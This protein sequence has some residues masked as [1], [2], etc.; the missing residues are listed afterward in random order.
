MENPGIRPDAEKR[1]SWRLARRRLS[2]MVSRVDLYP[3]VEIATA[4]VAVVIG[5][6]SYALVSGVRTPGAGLSPAAANVLPGAQ[7]P[8]PIVPH[9]LI[10]RRPAR[11]GWHPSAGH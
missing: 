8:A 5:L 2:R 10:H 1:R 3:R 6:P 4:V 11:F 7:L 9:P